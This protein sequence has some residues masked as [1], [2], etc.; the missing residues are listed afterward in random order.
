MD[1]MQKHREVLKKIV[2][3]NK[4]KAKISYAINE[5]L[6]ELAAVS[7]ELGELSAE[8]KPTTICAN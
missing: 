4:R 3:L 2:V 1:E 8:L 6:N 7:A 5:K